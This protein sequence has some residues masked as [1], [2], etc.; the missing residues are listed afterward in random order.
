MVDTEQENYLIMNNSIHN[1][2]FKRF[3]K[4]FNIDD[5]LSYETSSMDF[6][7]SNINIDYT[8]MLITMQV[9]IQFGKPDNFTEQID[10]FKKDEDYDF[11][12]FLKTHNGFTS[13][14][15]MGLVLQSFTS[16]LGIN[17]YNKNHTFSVFDLSFKIVTPIVMDLATEENNEEEK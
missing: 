4:L 11:Y 16:K 5:K 14:M 6:D 9:P 1:S 7:V 12:L 15:Q 17:A 2:S 13:V 8:N 10:F 3:N